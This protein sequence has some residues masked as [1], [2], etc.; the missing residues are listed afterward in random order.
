[1]AAHEKAGQSDEWYTPPWI[2]KALGCRFDLDVSSPG[3]HVTPWVPAKRFLT[4]DSLSQ[5][6][7]GMVWMNPPFGGRNAV[8]PWVRKFVAH[9]N[10]IA[11]MPNRTGAEWWHHWAHGCDVLLFVQGKI[12]FLRPD[13]SE[14]RSPGYGNVL[15]AAGKVASRVLAFAGI[16]GV[17]VSHHDAAEVASNA[18]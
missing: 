13:G 14:G 5:E 2:F 6:W 3:Q 12:R 16:S 18:A 9:R 1:M 15:G 8:L 4:A 11:L 7:R 10:G 17:L